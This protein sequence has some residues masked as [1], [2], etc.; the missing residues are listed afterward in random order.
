M[1]LQALG[2]EDVLPGGG[3]EQASETRGVPTG[4]WLHHR[5]VGGGRVGGRAHAGQLQAQQQEETALAAPPAG[6]A[7]LDSAGLGLGPARF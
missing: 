5:P 2:R 3:G 1:Q 6:R 4:K 7:P